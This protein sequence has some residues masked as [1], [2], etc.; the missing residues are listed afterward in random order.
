MKTRIHI[1]RI[2][3]YLVQLAIVILCYNFMKSHFL[4]IL[5]VIVAGAPVL[6]LAGVF[7]L[8]RGIDLTIRAPE[9]TMEKGGMGYLII[10]LVNK[11]IIPSLDAEVLLESENSFYG[12]KASTVL[13]IPVRSLGDFE[14]YIPVKYTMNGRYSYN[15]STI[16]FRDIL[17]IISLRKKLDKKCEIAVLPSSDNRRQFNTSDMSVGMTESEET[18][19]KGHDFSDVSD[20]RE[21]IPGDKLMSIHWKLSAKKDT[22]M[23]KD[24]VAMSDQQMVIVTELAGRDEEV[25]E[26]LTLTYGIV[27]A[28]IAEQVFVRLMW[29]SEMGYEFHEQQIMNEENLKESFQA[30]YYEKIYKDPNKTRLLMRSIRP[31]LKAYVNIC[32][33]DKGADAVVVE[34]D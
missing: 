11:T 18:L 16:R 3:A 6:S 30:I 28:F 1:T 12:D 26:I 14:K 33:T 8:K 2:I 13:S 25:D 19:K 4:L 9:E 20:V 17:G 5:L 10:K 34:Q 7:V 27:K 32:M 31:E 22:L 29:W 21:Y 15:V 24:R 23:V